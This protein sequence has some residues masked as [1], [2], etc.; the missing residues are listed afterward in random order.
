MIDFNQGSTI[1]WNVITYSS[2]EGDR[3]LLISSLETFL[4]SIEVACGLFE[5]TATTSL[6]SLSGL[7]LSSDFLL[8]R[9]D[10]G[11]APEKV[12]V[13]SFIALWFG[14]LQK[15]ILFVVI[16]YPSLTQRQLTPYWKY[17]WLS[18]HALWHR[19]FFNSKFTNFMWVTTRE[20]LVTTKV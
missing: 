11:V 1:I 7:R 12:V 17:E 20:N 13:G 16:L 6:G 3:V 2:E 18:A 5:V 10:L 9:M 8:F 15:M 19:G 14:D 4:F